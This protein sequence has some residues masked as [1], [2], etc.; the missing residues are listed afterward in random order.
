M[1]AVRNI[2]IASSVINIPLFCETCAA[3]IKFIY[4]MLS[5]M[6]VQIFRAIDF[7]ATSSLRIAKLMKI[8]FRADVPD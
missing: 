7:L 6:V 5:T 8:V 4:M 3:R 1:S 2:N